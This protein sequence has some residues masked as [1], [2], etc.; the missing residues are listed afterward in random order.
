[1]I[2]CMTV[3]F[4]TF[5][6]GTPYGVLPILEW[7]GFTLCQ[8]MAIARFLGKKIGMAGESE[9]EA[10]RADMALDLVMD[11]HEGNKKGQRKRVV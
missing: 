1:M 9:E 5:P 2:I 4:Q 11:Y 7:D 8:S 6:S 10:A 3:R